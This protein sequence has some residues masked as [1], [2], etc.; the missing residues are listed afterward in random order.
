M[1]ITSIEASKQAYPQ[2][3]QNHKE[4]M[5]AFKA[6]ALSEKWIVIGFQNY[7]NSCSAIIIS[8]NPIGDA[9]PFSGDPESISSYQEG[10]KIIQLAQYERSQSNPW[11]RQ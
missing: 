4:A 5:S 10:M 7:G 6:M 9:Y 3:N 1:F 11:T 2:G 8:K